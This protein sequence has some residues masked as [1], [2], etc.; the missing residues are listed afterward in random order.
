MRIYVKSDPKD[1]GCFRVEA[2]V[3]RVAGTTK[4]VLTNPIRMSE[5]TWYKAKAIA[6]ILPIDSKGNLVGPI[7]DERLLEMLAD[8]FADPRTL[9]QHEVT[10][11][12]G[13]LCLWAT[14]ENIKR[15]NRIVM[16]MGHVPGCRNLYRV[17]RLSDGNYVV[18]DS[19]ISFDTLYVPAPDLH[20][21]TNV[22]DLRYMY[23]EI[24]NDNA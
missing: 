18:S 4:I 1:V 20:R 10:F 17:A 19:H 15:S 16:V 3:V 7:E 5:S 2:S 12:K 6:F 22:R 23:D 13:D 8:E 14:Q 9:L 11:R 24:E 21:I